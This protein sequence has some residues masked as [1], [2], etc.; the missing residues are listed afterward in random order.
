MPSKHNKNP[1]KHLTKED[2]ERQEANKKE[3]ARKRVV[4]VEKFYPALIEATVSVDEAKALINA[5]G[6]LLMEDTLRTMRE[7][8]FADI[9]QSLQDML[10]RDGE[11]VPEIKKL[12]ETLHGE[13]LFVAREIIEGMTRAIEAM[14]TE[15]LRGRRLDTLKPHWEA[16]LN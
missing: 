7:R 1:Q 5:L 6:T 11:R 2:L 15:E 14:V 16:Y 9:S 10:C 12:L 8:K 3:I 13:N 4:I